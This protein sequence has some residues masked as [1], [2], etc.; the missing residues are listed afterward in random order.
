MNK[1]PT[2]RVPLKRVSKTNSRE[3][4]KVLSTYLGMKEGQNFTLH[5]ITQLIDGFELDRKGRICKV[6]IDDSPI[7]L[8]LDE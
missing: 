8:D 2:R 1:K 3:Y 6:V 7:Y 4:H 5:I